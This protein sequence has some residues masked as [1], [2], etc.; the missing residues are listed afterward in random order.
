LSDGI[1]ATLHKTHRCELVADH[2]LR[3]CSALSQ[4]YTTVRVA[5]AVLGGLIGGPVG[6][7]V[8]AVAGSSLYK[9]DDGFGDFAKSAGRTTEQVLERAKKVHHYV[10]NTRRTV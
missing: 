5:G 2:S 8:G 3:K 6:A 4:T 9:R 1:D 10:P 7:V